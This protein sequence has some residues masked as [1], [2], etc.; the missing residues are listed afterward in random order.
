[1]A[2][3]LHVRSLIEADRWSWQGLYA[4][5]ARFYNALLS[6]EIADRLWGWL[7]DSRHPLEGL[8]CLT[9]TT[10]IGLLHLRACP[11]PLS[12]QD[13]GFVD[14][15]Y[16]DADHRGS[17]AA[18]RLALAARDIAI[19]RGWPRLRWVTQFYNTAGRRVYDRYTG[20]PSDFIL[21]D[22]PTRD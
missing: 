11:H 7:L 8:L 21:Y 19:A 20:G 15:L 14:D 10:T 17:G 6:D 3:N 16:V 22:W 5:Y 9:G 12:A 18:D 13:I 4:G 2:S 1:M